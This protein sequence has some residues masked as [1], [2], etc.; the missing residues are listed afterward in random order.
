M[1]HPTPRFD[2]DLRAH[3]R[4][5]MA[6]Y[7]GRS[8][9]VSL[10]ARARHGQRPSRNARRSS[11]GAQPCQTRRWSRRAWPAAHTVS[12]A[13]G[14]WTPGTVAGP[15]QAGDHWNSLPAATKTESV[16]RHAAGGAGRAEAGSGCS[17]S[18][19]TDLCGG[20]QQW[21]SL[22]DQTNAL[23]SA[24]LFRTETMTSQSKMWCVWVHSPKAWPYKPVDCSESIQLNQL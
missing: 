5:S 13:A 2:S 23:G 14:S 9:A 12:S 4:A 10:C 3:V 15:A 18:A 1:R 17:N 19:R 16:A 7:Q 22:R 21:P 6:R 20:G 8:R 11:S 24:H